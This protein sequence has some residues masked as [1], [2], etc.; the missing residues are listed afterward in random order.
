MKK[1]S[2]G[3]KGTSLA[4]DVWSMDKWDQNDDELTFVEKGD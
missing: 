3:S 2:I 4:D 1:E